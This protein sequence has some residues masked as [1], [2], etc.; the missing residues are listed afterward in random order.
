MTQM[1]AGTSTDVGDALAQHHEAI[2]AQAHREAAGR[3]GVEPGVREHAAGDSHRQRHRQDA[4]RVRLDDHGVAGRG[5]H[6]V[7]RWPARECGDLN[8]NTL[9]N[10]TS[11]RRRD[12]HLGSGR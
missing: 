4:G 3:R 11:N 5:Q 8:D 2:E 1:T 10:D 7:S 6:S 9:S 12:Q